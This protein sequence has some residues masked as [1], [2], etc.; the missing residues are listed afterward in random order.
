MQIYQI[1]LKFNILNFI[2]SEQMNIY[3]VPTCKQWFSFIKQ[4]KH[5]FLQECSEPET[6]EMSICIIMYINILTLK[7][8]TCGS[9]REK[10][11]TPIN[12]K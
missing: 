9:I 6:T 5:F 3:L 2:H 4:Q 8:L 12:P 10:F 1:K 7:R 11:I